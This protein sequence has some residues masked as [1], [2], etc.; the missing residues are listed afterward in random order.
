MQSRLLILNA[1]I[2][3][4][5]YSILLQ[6]DTWS[7]EA[8]GPGRTGYRRGR[9]RRLVPLIQRESV[10]DVSENTQGASGRA[11]GAIKRNTKRFK[12]LVQN[13]NPDI[14]FRDDERTGADRM[15]TQV[16]FTRKFLRGFSQI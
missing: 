9:L 2:L 1:I 11:E 3:V 14:E 4:L 12:D 8:C 16:S 7:V 6:P 15:M 13:W 5:G 10:P